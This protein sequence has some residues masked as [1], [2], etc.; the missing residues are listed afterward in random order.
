MGL[1]LEATVLGHLRRAF[2]PFYIKHPRGEIGAAYVDGERCRAIEVKWTRQL[3]PADL[4]LASRRPGTIVA[5]RVRHK[6]Q[7]SGVPVLPAPVV[8]L[9]LARQAS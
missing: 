2:P 4:C 5:G 6:G 7:V 1:E 9:R 3:R 8:L